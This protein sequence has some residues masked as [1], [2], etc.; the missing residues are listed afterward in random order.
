M[1]ITYMS[2]IYA[3]L[4][5]LELAFAEQKQME[6][7]HKVA[8]EKRREKE[9]LDEKTKLEHDRILEVRERCT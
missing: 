5:Q 7:Q 2:H 3:M 9:R 8:E 6:H 1:C 4:F